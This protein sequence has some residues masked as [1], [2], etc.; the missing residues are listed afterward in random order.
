MAESPICWNMF[1]GK[2]I[3]N[4]AMYLRLVLVGPQVAIVANDGLG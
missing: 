4:C 3:E 2:N 1:V